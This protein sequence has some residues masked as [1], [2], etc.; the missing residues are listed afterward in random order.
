MSYNP[1]LEIQQDIPL[2]EKLLK[3]GFWL[4]FLSFIMAPTGYLIKMMISRT[5]SVEDIGLFYSV[6]WF[7]SILTTYNDLWLTDSLQY[8]LP[9]Y[10]IDKDYVKAKSLLVFTRLSQ[11]ITWILIGWFLV[12]WAPWLA[13]NYFSSPNAV[14]LLRIFA[15]YF[16]ILNLFQVIQ[17]IFTATQSVKIASWIDAI[18]LR[19]VVWFVA[20]YWFLD[21]L[22]LYHFAWSRVGWLVVWTIAGIIFSYYQLA[23]LWSHKINLTKI[24]IKER[25]WYGFWILIW[26][27]AATIFG[28][29]D[30]QF[31]LLYFGKQAAWYWSNYMSMSAI[32]SIVT[33][34]LIGYFLPLFTEL[35]KK[36]A[37]SELKKVFI[38]SYCRFGLIG[39]AVWIFAYFLGPRVAVLL[40]GPQFAVSWDLYRF[41]APFM[42]AWLFMSINFQY[43]AWIWMVKI[44][45][46]LVII[47]I[48]ITII[49]NFI[50]A[51]ILWLR[52]LILW[53]AVSFIFLRLWTCRIIFQR[54]EYRISLSWLYK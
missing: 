29:I 10:F 3:K 33:V 2:K 48:I 51:P 14:I 35:T 9:Q 19:T 6:V 15:L 24:D 4:Y 43:L 5:L 21:S 32:L 53:N 46:K 23:R 18:R 27:N 12:F 30:Q 31:A 37:Y 28:Q 7:I 13:T 11:F 1:D 34:P 40:F 22:T 20:S 47:A 16:L 41:S 45:V 8:Y 42:R 38:F 49:I 54:S 44:R 26:S 25:W 50:S 39:V 17:S 52:G 36:S